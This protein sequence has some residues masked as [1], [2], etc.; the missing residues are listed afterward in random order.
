MY[1]L[2]LKG[3]ASRE[4]K[5]WRL[6]AGR[7]KSHERAPKHIV[8]STDLRG[9]AAPPDA[10]ETTQTESQR[11]GRGIILLDVAQAVATAANDAYLGSEDGLEPEKGLA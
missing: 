1:V 7:L 6:L 8:G 4:G 2:G 9:L 11:L 10:P 5:T 3:P